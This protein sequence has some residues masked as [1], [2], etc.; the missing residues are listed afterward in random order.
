MPDLS[1]RHA[2]TLTRLAAQHGVPL[3]DLEE[4]LDQHKLP[5]PVAEALLHLATVEFRSLARWGQKAE[6]TRELA[7][8]LRDNSSEAGPR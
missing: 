6:Y 2:P 7:R 1:E 3:S 8:V 5:A 4:L